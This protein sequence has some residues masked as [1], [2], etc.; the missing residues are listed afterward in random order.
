MKKYMIVKRSHLSFFEAVLRKRP[1]GR[2]WDCIGYIVTDR[3]GQHPE[4]HAELNPWGIYPGYLKACVEK[5]SVSK[6]ELF[7]KLL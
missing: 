5:R 2:G 1:S 7:I 3:Q 6:K 4:F